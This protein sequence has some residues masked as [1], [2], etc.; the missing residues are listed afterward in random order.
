MLRSSDMKYMDL[1]LWRRSD[2]F[3][4]DFVPKKELQP[5]W[6][7]PLELGV[8]TTYQWAQLNI[9]L[10]QIRNIMDLAIIYQLSRSVGVDE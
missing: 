10:E 8:Q 7:V 3:Q 5:V 4:E 1:S 6:E 2:Y 9:S